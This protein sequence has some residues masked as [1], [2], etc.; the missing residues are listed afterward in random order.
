[1]NKCNFTQALKKALREE[2]QKDSSVF[3]LGEDIGLRGGVYGVTEG[4]R[5][6]FETFK[7]IGTKSMPNS[8]SLWW[9]IYS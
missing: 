3:V 4:F 2:M 8:R 7:K 5:D 9:A 1:M 6:E